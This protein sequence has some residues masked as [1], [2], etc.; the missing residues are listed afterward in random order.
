VP[1]IVAGAAR[2]RRL[3]VPTGGGTRPTSDRAREGLFS[4]LEA[5]LG[6]LAGRR[7]L[8][9]YAGSGAVG[10]EAFSR[11]AAAVRL[12][13]SD[14]RALLALRANVRS[15]AGPG[16]PGTEVEVSPAPVGRVLAG[17]PP[18]TPYDV[19]F[20]DPPYDRA[21]RDLHGDLTSLRRGWCADDAVTVVER[22]SR[23]GWAWPPGWA[24]LRER[25]YGEATLWYGRAAGAPA[26]R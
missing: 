16:G 20:L 22:S 4:T 26:D 1:R 19:V 9:L 8:D 2:G 11:G 18:A 5:L 21:E 7:V 12:V 25:R 3:A 24:A 23:S 6:S 13:E 10:L 17:D 14:R 15:V